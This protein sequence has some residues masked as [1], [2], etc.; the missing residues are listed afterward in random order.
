MSTS[1][2]LTIAHR[3]LVYLP[4]SLYFPQH[5]GLGRIKGTEK[6]SG[7]FDERGDPFMWQVTTT[8]VR[9]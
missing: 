4:D 7:T 9:G 3:Q 1:D 6:V 5:F 8:V 2:S